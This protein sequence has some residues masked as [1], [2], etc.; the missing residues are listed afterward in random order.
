MTEP[1]DLEANAQYLFNSA[2]ELLEQGKAD[3]AC[4][5]LSRHPGQESEVRTAVNDAR[6]YLEWLQPARPRYKLQDPNPALEPGTSLGAYQLVSKLGEGGM[7]CVFRA[8]QEALEGREVALKVMAPGLADG[9]TRISERFRREAALAAGVHHPNVA[10][11]YDFGE[12]QG[13]PY[14]TMQLVEGRTLLDVLEGIAHR[15]RAGTIRVTGAEYVR[16]AVVLARNVA[17]GLAAIHELGLVHRDVK[18]SNILLQ[19]AG[20]DEEDALERPPVVVDF[21]LLRSVEF[22]DLT[23]AETVLGTAAF[24]AP[25]VRCGEDVDARADVFA[26]GVVLYDLLAIV[27]PGERPLAAG[28]LED[29]RLRN[30]GVDPRLAAIVRM[31]I[32]RQA[33]L[34]YADG[35]GFCSELDAYLD[36]RPIRAL[37]G[38][39]LGRLRLWARR[40]PTRALKASAIGLLAATL[41][42]FLFLFTENVVSMYGAARSA[43]SLEQRG[44]LPGA[45]R[46]YREILDQS[47]LASWLPWF[48]GDLLRAEAY[49]PTTRVRAELL[50]TAWHQFADGTPESLAIAHENLLHYLSTTPPAPLEDAVFRFL[51]SGL[52]QKSQDQRRFQAA[53]TLAHYFLVFHGPDARKDNLACLKEVEEAL[54]RASWAYRGQIDADSVKTRYYIACALG[55]TRLHSA[56]ALISDFEAEDPELR[57]IA[58]TSANRLYRRAILGCVEADGAFIPEIDQQLLAR[59]ALGLL[60]AADEPGPGQFPFDHDRA[61]PLE[62]EEQDPDYVTEARHLLEHIAWIRNR[63]HEAK[64][65]DDW[66][67][68]D[69][70]T[71]YLESIQPREYTPLLSLDPYANTW[72]LSKPMALGRIE[73]PGAAGVHH[74]ALVEFSE[75][76][77]KLSGAPS[78]FEW[79]GAD[80]YNFNT[81]TVVL[82]FLHPGRSE[83]RFVVKIPR[84]TVS[85]RI[86]VTHQSPKRSP[87][88]GIGGVPV[89]FS[90]ESGEYKVI[91][92][93]TS[94]DGLIEAHVIQIPERLIVGRESIELRI[95]LLNAPALYWLRSLELKFETPGQ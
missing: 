35:A 90:V 30:T 7:G 59:V 45:A 10:E 14:F 39:A 86:H 47:S 5:L 42:G 76:Q 56:E 67:I 65:L 18:H 19:G 15:R 20:P 60:W 64:V 2:I 29:V 48:E 26:L 88:P 23:G 38:S 78:T 58:L 8:R 9:D 52:E 32:E 82:E 51:T 61:P 24:S 28:G 68:P 81:D 16:R 70:L 27:G 62:P 74:R 54:V 41:A 43:A 17:A 69:G 3:P 34:R 57:R 25:E 85:A 21:G 83:A 50:S 36:D 80:I 93:V 11:I 87:L 31:A 79:S 44:D 75:L 95:R 6:K 84:Q 77:A 63:L 4:D 12:V 1:T 55:G 22:S 91:Q 37:P 49:W 33:A 53:K 92:H 66:S 46:A 13:V 40:S 89:E 94:D 72:D 73:Y 71:K